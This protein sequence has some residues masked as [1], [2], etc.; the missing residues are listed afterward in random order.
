MVQPAVLRGGLQHRVFAADLVGKGRDAE[1]VL[2]A[3]HHVQVGHAG[4]DH[5]HVGAFGDV[6]RYFAQRLVGVGRVHLVDLFIALAQVGGRAHGVAERAVEGAGVLGAVGH[7][8]GVNQPLLLQRLTD[9]GDAP[10]HHV[11]GRDDVDAGL[12]LHQRLLHQHRHGFVVH[13][14]AGFARVRV[15]QPVLAVAGERVQRHVGHHTEFREAVLQ[16]AHHARH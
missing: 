6:H 16:R 10:V 11:A 7:D 8:A 4:L 2:H 13:D 9:R 14:V 5:H 3:P 12:G 1:L 15:Q